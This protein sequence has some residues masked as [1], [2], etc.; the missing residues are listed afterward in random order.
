MVSS[1]A[2]RCISLKADG[3]PRYKLKRVS[4]A[5]KKAHL[6]RGELLLRWVGEARCIF[7]WNLEATI[8]VLAST[9]RLYKFDDE[10]S[11]CRCVR[12]P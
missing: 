10:P 11:G 1:V 2:R 7:F 5:L 3:V 12:E 4:G 9:V 6:A 8:Q